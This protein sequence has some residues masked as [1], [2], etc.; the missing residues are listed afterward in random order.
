[1]NDGHNGRPI[2]DQI[3]NAVSEALQSGDYSNLNGLVLR[4]M[5]DTLSEAGV[6]I[7][8]ETIYAQKT[9]IGQQAGHQEQQMNQLQQIH[10]AQQ[11]YQERVN[12]PQGE[13]TKY[14][15]KI[16]PQ[17]K[18][19]PRQVKLKKAGDRAVLFCQLFGATGFLGIIVGGIIELFQ[20][21][22]TGMFGVI[23]LLSM[24]II[25]GMMA[26]PFGGIYIVGFCLQR[27]LKQKNGSERLQRKNPDVQID[28]QKEVQGTEEILHKQESELNTM[29]AEGME[30]VRRLRDL[31]DKIPGEVI[32]DKLYRL[33]NLLKEIFDNVKI[34]PEQLYRIHKLMDYYLPTTLKLV[35]AYEEFDRVSVPGQELLGAKAEIENTLDTIN[36]AFRELLNKL[37]QSTVSD[38]TIEAQVLKSMLANEGLTKDGVFAGETK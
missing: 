15:N 38:V 2:G 7:T 26:M 17:K 30:C 4:T 31:N 28:I 18:K 33:E 16:I 21:A 37:F 29:M 36:Q 9:G 3:N 35:E 27:S 23:E 1:M 12:H 8:L 19:V 25:F 11:M 22:I 6:Q 10:Q 14:Q 20:M 24:A 13:N 34:H 5:N 32:S